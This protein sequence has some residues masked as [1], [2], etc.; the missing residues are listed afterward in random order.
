[1]P[2]RAAFEQ[3]G[4]PVEEPG[5]LGAAGSTA[6]V[7]LVHPLAGRPTRVE[8]DWS[9]F[10]AAVLSAEVVVVEGETCERRRV[11]ANEPSLSWR[12]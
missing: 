4:R 6:T 5:R 10:N 2:A 8:L 11:S 3:G 9:L 12:P 1:V 7:T